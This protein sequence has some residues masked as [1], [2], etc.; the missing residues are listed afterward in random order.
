MQHTT[1]LLAPLLL[2]ALAP[3]AT[4]QAPA[5][6]PSPAPSPAIGPVPPALDHP[7]ISRGD[8]A[9]AVEFLLKAIEGAPTDPGLAQTLVELRQQLELVPGASAA[10][11]KRLAAVAD[12]MPASFLQDDVL[13]A[14]ADLQRAAGDL[15]GNTAT[16]QRRGF[17]REWLVAG[18]FGLAPAASLHEPFEPELAASERVVDPKARFAAVRGEVGWVPLPLEPHE[19][20]V[21]LSRAVTGRGAV[22]YA[23]THLELAAD[24]EGTLSYTGPSAR[25]FVN[26]ALVGV[27]DRT[28]ERLDSELRLP[29]T[30]RKGSNRVLVKVA[31][32]RSGRFTLRVQDR[33]G[34]VVRVTASQAPQP[35]DAGADSLDPPAPS[36]GL[37]RLALEKAPARQALYAQALLQTGRGEEGCTVLDDL[38][39]VAPDL[40]K[41]AWFQL[42]RGDAAQRADH[43]PSAARRDQAR[44]SYQKALALDP[45]SVRARRRLAEFAI[46]DDQVK[47]AVLLLEECLEL[48]PSDLATRLR[49]HE[50]LL[51]KGW[52]LPAE[53]ALAEAE[54]LGGELPPILRARAALHERRGEAA[55]ARAV[56]ERLFAKF[57]GELWVI[58]DRLDEALTRGDRTGAEAALAAFA[59]ARV[60]PQELLG[61]RA[62]ACRA[63]GDRQGELALRREL[64]ARRPWD[65]DLVVGLAQLLAEAASREP[66]AKEE[67]VQ[68]LQGVL[69]REPGRHAA[70]R[71]L[72][73]LLP[74]E[75]KTGAEDFWREWQPDVAKLLA[76]L[77]PPSHW[78]RAQTVCI[79]DQT[80]TRI[81]PD[82]STVDVVHQLWL[83]LDE[84]GKERYGERPKAGQLITVRTITPSGESL[85]PIN[86][87]GS[88]YQMPGLAPGAIVEHAYRSERPAPVFQYTNGPFYFMDPDL[89]EPFWLSRWVIWVHK[90]APVTIIER[91]LDRRGI[92]HVVEER[93]DWRVHVITAKDQP[94]IE[95]EE[96][97]PEKEEYLPWVKIVERRT[98][99]ECGEFYREQALDASAVTPSVQRKADELTFGVDDD[100][101]KA[102]A[103]HRF[104]QEHVQRGG[105]EAD[106]AAQILA[107]RAGSKGTLFLGLLRAARVPFRQLLAGPNPSASDTIDWTLPEPGQFST[108]VIRIEPKDQPYVYVDPEAPRY[109]PFGRLPSS[110]WGAPAYVCEVG[111]GMLDTLPVEAMQLDADQVS[112]LDVTLLPE[113]KAKVELRRDW[114]SYGAYSM[115]EAFKT[116]QA[117]QLRNFFAQQA[118]QLFPGAKLTDAGALDLE[119][120][121]VPMAFRLAFDVPKAVSARGDGTLMLSK[122]VAP[123]NLKASLGARRVRE[124]DIVVREAYMVQDTV[125]LALG[126]Y[127]CPRLPRDVTLKTELGQFSLLYVR[128]GDGRVRVERVMSIRPG[129][130]TPRDYPA[131]REF[132]QAIDEAEQRTLVL[133]EKKLP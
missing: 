94:R 38:V 104:V 108:P 67:A 103:L 69:A 35:V 78:P 63:L 115:K 121:G 125:H 120:V 3:A 16:Q 113:G 76:E 101:A 60:A 68:L 9:A 4:A 88:G 112:T 124:F 45:K 87:Q 105:G 130:I 27:I 114:P 72:D 66:R 53:Q 19:V 30:L 98:L 52:L 43:L 97:A 1:R 100:L 111:G 99:A 90:D 127:T 5:P 58:G 44:Q 65:L 79:H 23:M 28:A 13:D 15:A 86:A 59:A 71:L 93:G 33:Q 6:A 74:T 75:Q 77:P 50:A 47:E 8:A 102:K 48:A 116:A 123:S 37:A 7:G 96:L 40:E 17:I 95:P 89:T 18:G 80:V 46:Q 73:G 36:E 117:Q 106:S 92:T 56:R 132:L 107:S 39:R 64:L 10:A 49:I 32:G 128:E 31:D 57:P 20:V 62:D 55:Q 110:L 14:V 126:P 42:L 119:A 131:F 25:I 122:L 82:G 70:R 83:L 133:E 2:L 85:E 29:V 81:G 54:K 41:A 11:Q 34:R 129:R 21:Q 109:A 26:R 51:R 118:N 61:R 84:Q 24:L 12:S 22:T 91:N